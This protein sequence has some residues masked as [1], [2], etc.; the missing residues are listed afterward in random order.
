MVMKRFFRLSTHTL[1]LSVSLLLAPACD[2]SEEPDAALQATPEPFSAFVVYVADGVWDPADP[3]AIPPTLEEIQR[4]LW[5]FDDGQIQAYEQEAAA[6]F[7]TRFGI[8]LADPAL[9]DSILYTPFGCDP[10]LGYR[11]VTMAGH[12]VDPEGWPM[13]DA[14]YLLTIIDPEGLD[15]GGEF[16]G[17]RAPAGTAM[18]FGRYTFETEREETVTVAFRSLTPYVNDPWGAATIRCEIDSPQLGSGQANLVFKLDQTGDGRFA[19][20][21]RNVLTFD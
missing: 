4:D 18:A 21:I 19:A 2:R 16:A 12:T 17:Q 5:G 11:V 9:A 20:M 10:R 8:D 14:G 1:S 7:L 15:L 13:C 6:F 3:D